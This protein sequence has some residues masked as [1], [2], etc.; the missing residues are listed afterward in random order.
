M[1]QW[2][3][4]EQDISSRN[5]QLIEKDYGTLKMDPGTI[6]DFRNKVEELRRD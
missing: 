6:I 3:S 1:G 4:L 2:L 5:V